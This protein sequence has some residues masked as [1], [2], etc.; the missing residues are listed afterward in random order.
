MFRLLILI[1]VPQKKES[2]ANYIHTYTSGGQTQSVIRFYPDLTFLSF[3]SSSSFFYPFFFI[4]SIL[5]LTVC[6]FYLGL[7]FI[8]KLCGDQGLSETSQWTRELQRAQAR[9]KQTERGTAS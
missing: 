8:V 4:L 7:K 2:L 3:L 9:V 1:T 5:K 6:V